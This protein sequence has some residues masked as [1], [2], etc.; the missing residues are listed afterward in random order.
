MQ[1]A[2]PQGMPYTSQSLSSIWIAYVCG[3]E[4]I[5]VSHSLFPLLGHVIRVE[6]VS[7]CTCE[8]G[9]SRLME[10]NMVSVHNVG[11]GAHRSNDTIWSLSCDHVGDIADALIIKIQVAKVLLTCVNQDAQEL[12][13]CDV[14][15][16]FG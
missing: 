12:E 7:V 6:L 4:Q 13:D 10:V 2:A 9:T 8:D 5:D 3:N 14:A 1:L 15:L 16:T 11:G